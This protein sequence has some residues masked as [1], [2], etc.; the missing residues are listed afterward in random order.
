MKALLNFLVSCLA[1][2]GVGL[3]HAVVF[4][5][6]WLWFIVPLGMVPVSILHSWGII[7]ILGL[8]NR[9][10][11]TDDN[12]GTAEDLLIDGLVYGLGAWGVGYLIHLAM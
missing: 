6:L 9:E 1:V 11:K 8:V 10:F 2:F 4:S 5:Y 7:V 3:V 12:K